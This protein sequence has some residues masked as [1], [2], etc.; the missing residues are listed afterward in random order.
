MATVLIQNHMR[1][2]RIKKVN[3]FE[4]IDYFRCGGIDMLN[5]YFQIKRQVCRILRNPLYTYINVL[6]V[7]K[8]MVSCLSPAF[9]AVL[10]Y[11]TSG[12][13]PTDPSRSGRTQVAC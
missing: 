13:V 3:V 1:H 8:N 6:F 5:I 2:S 11:R 9:S 4:T 12:G 10:L 7:S